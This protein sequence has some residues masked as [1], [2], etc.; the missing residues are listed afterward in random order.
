MFHVK[1]FCE[2]YD[3][4]TYDIEGILFCRVAHA[5]LDIASPVSVALG[6]VQRHETRMRA[7]HP[8]ADTLQNRM[9]SACE[10]MQIVVGNGLLCSVICWFFLALAGQ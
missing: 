3:C 8:E 9:P 1:H 4:E 2:A 5:A 6:C 10:L 7:V